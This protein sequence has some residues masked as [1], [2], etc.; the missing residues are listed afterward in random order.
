MLI[1]L[2]R[3]GRNE[4]PMALSSTVGYIILKMYVYLFSKI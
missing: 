2:F 4:V 3:T 1:Y